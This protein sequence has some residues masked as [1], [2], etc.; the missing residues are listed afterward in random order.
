[1]KEDMLIQ[2]EQ[3]VYEEESL[4]YREDDDT[5][6][7]RVATQMDNDFAERAVVLQEKNLEVNTQH[8]S[9]AMMSVTQ[10]NFTPLKK[11]EK[12]RFHMVSLSKL[13]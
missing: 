4:S 9:R 8:A 7:A 11:I 1:M 12:A 10:D 13:V 6:L 5:H 3:P 2:N